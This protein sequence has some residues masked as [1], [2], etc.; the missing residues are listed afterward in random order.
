MA[1][2][3]PAGCRCPP[4]QRR[5]KPVI[6]HSRFLDAVEGGPVLC[7]VQLRPN[8]TPS[9]KRQY[10]L[11]TRL[12][13]VFFDGKLMLYKEAVSAYN[14]TNTAF[15]YFSGSGPKRRSIPTCV[16]S[17]VPADFLASVAVNLGGAFLY[18]VQACLTVIGANPQRS[19]ASFAVIISS[20]VLIISPLFHCYVNQHYCDNDRSRYRQGIL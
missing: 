12:M 6:L 19:A 3:V 2:V 5:R 7:K 18:P 11:R 13:A 4:V 14:R 16:T 15:A 17:Q 1:I 10:P 20:N 9:Q 8:Q